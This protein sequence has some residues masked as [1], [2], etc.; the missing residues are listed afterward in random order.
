MDSMRWTA[1]HWAVWEGNGI[2]WEGH[3]A[4]QALLEAGAEIEI[5]D[6]DGMTALHWAAFDG[7]EAIVRLLLEAGACVKT[8]SSSGLIASSFARNYGHEGVVRLLEEK[9]D[10]TDAKENL[11]DASKEDLMDFKHGSD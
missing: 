5:Q 6:T 8:K 7:Q 2:I 4:V 3:E 1:L 10:D 11:Y 9:E